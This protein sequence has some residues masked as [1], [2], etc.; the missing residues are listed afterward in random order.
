MTLSCQSLWPVD[1]CMKGT[2][3]EREVGNTTIAVC[4]CDAGFSRSPEFQYLDEDQL[5]NSLCSF[6]AEVV[7]YLFLAAAILVT[8][9]LVLQLWVI[10]YNKE[11]YK[12]QLKRLF[13]TL[14]SLVAFCIASIYR[15]LNSDISNSPVLFGKDVFFTFLIANGF[16]FF[17]VAVYVFILKAMHLLVSDSEWTSTNVQNYVNNFQRTGYML[18]IFEIVICQLLWIS[19]FVTNNIVALSLVRVFLV[20]NVLVEIHITYFTWKLKRNYNQDLGAVTEF[21]FNMSSRDLD[22]ISLQEINTW[23]RRNQR[24]M[25]MIT[26]SVTYYVS[27]CIIALWLPLFI[28]FVLQ[29]LWSYILPVVIILW[30]IKVLLEIYAGYQRKRRRDRGNR[31]SRKDIKTRNDFAKHLEINGTITRQDNENNIF[32]ILNPG[33]NGV[34]E[35]ED[36]LI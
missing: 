4:T 20:V 2:C 22:A 25:K 31:K 26:N 12:E 36:E 17:L 13:P 32:N 35:S 23:K 15:A 1:E 8:V 9:A 3:S 5:S 34:E 16:G 18:M 28:P 7:G 11:T 14:V 10:E 6:N 27:C 29:A 19:S 21:K 30:A 33:I 24:K